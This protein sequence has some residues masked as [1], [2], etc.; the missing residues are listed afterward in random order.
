MVSLCVL[1]LFCTGVHR[2]VLA[3][4][5]RLFKW[6]SCWVLNFEIMIRNEKKNLINKHVIIRD[7]K[8]FISSGPFGIHPRILSVPLS[9]L[10]EE[11]LLSIHFQMIYCRPNYGPIAPFWFIG[12]ISSF[13]VSASPLRISSFHALNFIDSHV[14]PS[15]K[16][17][18]KKAAV[19]YIFH[20]CISRGLKKA[21]KRKGL[22]TA[23]L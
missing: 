8:H 23:G 20:L 1:S 18:I 19:V 12:A 15:F 4:H 11:T 3:T 22:K 16:A 5:V 21:I 6:C 13:K 2:L 10:S 9:P 14:F 7:L 17:A